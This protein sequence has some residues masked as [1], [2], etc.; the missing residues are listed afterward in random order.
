MQ[1]KIGSASSMDCETDRRNGNLRWGVWKIKATKNRERSKRK[2]TVGFCFFSGFGCC[3]ISPSPPLI[4]QCSPILGSSSDQVY[5][6]WYTTCKYRLQF[7]SNVWVLVG[8]WFRF[9]FGIGKDSSVL[10]ANLHSIRGIKFGSHSGQW[11]V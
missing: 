2:S 8:Y 3:K 1:Q 4:L 5:N 10:F 7:C 6:L 9:V 11:I